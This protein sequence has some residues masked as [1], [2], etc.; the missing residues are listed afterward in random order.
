VII[1]NRRIA[2]RRRRGTPRA[3]A[4]TLMLAVSLMLSL[5]ACAEGPRI[6]I[7]GP[8]GQSLVAIGVEIADNSAKREVGLMYRRNMDEYAGMIFVFGAPANQHFW[9]RNTLI[10][11]DMIFAD[12]TGKIIGIVPN[13]VPMTDAD[14]SVPGDS[15]YVLEVN[16][17]FCAR[18]GVKAG[19]LLHFVGF[20]PKSLD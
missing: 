13:A 1:A 7:T 11:L 5:A 2:P 8:G 19:D 17:G 6:E 16:G 18:H 12:S 20:V 3:I 14:D 4:A 15:L 9:M 10:P